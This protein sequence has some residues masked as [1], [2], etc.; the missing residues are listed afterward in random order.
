MGLPKT[1]RLKEEIEP[2]VEAY[3]EK[4]GIR[5]ADLVNLALERFISEPQKIELIPISDTEWEDGLKKAYKKHKN[6]MDKLK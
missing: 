6:A 5:F 2:K 4:N 1:I 3:I